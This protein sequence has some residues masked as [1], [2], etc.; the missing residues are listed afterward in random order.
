MSLARSE[1]T[2]RVIEDHL[3]PAVE[4]A[5][6]GTR[7]RRAAHLTLAEFLAELYQRR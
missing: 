7:Q 5:L 6:P 2:Q 3:S 1:G 4:R